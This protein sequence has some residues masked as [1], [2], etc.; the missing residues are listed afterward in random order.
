MGYE[1]EGHP[2]HECVTG[3]HVVNIFSFSKA[4][5]MMGWRMGYLAFPPRLKDELMKVQDTI[6]ICPA[7]A[8]QKAALAAVQTGRS[9]VKDHVRDLSQNRRTVVEAVEAS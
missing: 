2:A 3:D 6:A 5:G 1:A 4:Y 9:W 8:S 7:I